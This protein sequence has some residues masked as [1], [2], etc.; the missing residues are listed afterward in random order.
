MELNLVTEFLHLPLNQIPC[1]ETILILSG[2]SD[3]IMN[4]SHLLAVS[5][6]VSCCVV[7]NAN[8]AKTYIAYIALTKCS[9]HLE[10]L[11]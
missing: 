4:Y 10:T 11:A 2:W 5:K 1:T 3:E 9:V 7:Q 6:F 8:A